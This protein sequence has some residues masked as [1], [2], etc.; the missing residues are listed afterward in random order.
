MYID[1]IYKGV[2]INKK[3]NKSEQVKVKKETKRNKR[4]KKISKK[5]NV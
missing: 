3:D 4:S 5:K 1:H 2:E